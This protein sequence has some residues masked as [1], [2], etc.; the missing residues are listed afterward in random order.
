MKK[1][2][3]IFGTILLML[4]WSSFSPI[5]QAVSPPPDGGYPGGNTA[6][7]QSALFSLTTGGYNTAVG[8]FSLRSDAQGQ[9]NTALGAGTLFANAGDPSTGAGSQNTATGAAALLS[10]TTGAANTANG[11][12]SLFS[13]TTG[14]H[15]TAN[16]A[17]ALYFNTTG[18]YDTA[19]GAAALY[20]NTTGYSN[21]ANG[22]SA[23]FSNT[24]GVNN[25]ASGLN[26]LFMNTTGNANTAL[27]AYAGSDLTTG[28]GNIDIASSGV[29]AESN[30]IRVGTT[31]TATYIAGIRGVST[32][33][34][35][36][37]AVVIDSAGQLGTASSSER[38][39]KD[40]KAMDKVSEA[41]LALRA[42]TFHYKND[43]KGVPQFGLIAEEVA[44]VNPDLVV[45]DK[46]GEIYTVRY[47]AVNA[48][49]LNEFLKEHRQVQEQ[50]AILARLKGELQSRLAEQQEHIQ[51]LTAG[52]Q[53]VSAQLA[54]VSSADGELSKPAPYAVLNNP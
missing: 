38:F 37:I 6:E 20:N 9:F 10:N 49:L 17:Q 3:V 41:I 35:D 43:A 46:S 8:Y 13:N 19:D 1:L 5:V 45:R 40:I 24:T 30:T 25:T 27:G 51:Q 33:I 34:A 44:K 28:S 36:A 48:M 53:K 50:K 23:L 16:G 29:A 42:V 11:A 14:G 4:G 54:A 39:K 31:Q 32:G 18:V 52:L 7:G 22:G 47:D 15:N 2:A 26:A 12:F 21:T